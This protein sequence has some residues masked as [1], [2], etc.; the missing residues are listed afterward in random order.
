MSNYPADIANEA[1]DAAGVDFTIGDMQDGTKP[2]QVVLRH[3]PQCLRQ[4]LRSAHWDMAR[5]QAPLLMLADATG[6]T[7]GVGTVVPAP[8]VYE[9][10][11]PVDCMK[12]RF[13]PANYLNPNAVPPGNITTPVTVPQTSVATQAPYGF[14]MRLVPSPFLIMLDTNYPVD[15]DSNW[16][17]V[18]GESPGGRV[19]VLS[20]INQAQ[21]VYTAFMPYPSVWDS[22][23]RG[24]LV[25][26]LASRIAMPLAKDKAF[27]M[28]MRDQLFGL[29]RDA[30]RQARIT[31]GNESSWPQTVD[32]V[33][34]F[35][36]ARWTGPGGS[37]G[38]SPFN[39][40]WGVWGMGG[41]GFNG[42]GFMGYGWDAAVF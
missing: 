38:N 16:L 33:A 27:G 2:A 22:Q 11:L 5:K 34:D 35:T 37:W 31:N 25:A 23:F 14:G 18:Q 24:A 20:N 3:Y 39:A 15:P 26:F 41:F 42:I 8:W 32:R 1:L 10:A 40:G 36:Q 4:L 17:E 7:D 30:V 12:G 9:Y 19:V 6:Q 21:M 29:A 13:V 28:K